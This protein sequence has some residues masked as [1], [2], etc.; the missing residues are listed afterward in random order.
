LEQKLEIKE[1]AIVVCNGALWAIT[2][3]LGEDGEILP[4]TTFYS[5]DGK[6]DYRHLRR[7]KFCI[8]EVTEYVIVNTPLE[9]LYINKSNENLRGD[10]QMSDNQFP[11]FDNLSENV[12]SDLTKAGAPTTASSEAFAGE[13][14]AST[15]GSTNPTVAELRKISASIDLS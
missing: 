4:S 7:A 12:V 2:D 14:Q 1:N 5:V 15:G 11:S 9:A 6:N 8:C 3:E 13:G 10:L